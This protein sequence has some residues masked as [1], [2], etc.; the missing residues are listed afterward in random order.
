MSIYTCFRVQNVQSDPVLQFASCSIYVFCYDF[1]GPVSIALHAGFDST[2]STSSVAASGHLSAWS[3]EKKGL[4]QGW[5]GLVGCIC[6]V[7]VGWFPSAPLHWVNQ[8]RRAISKRFRNVDIWLTFGL[9]FCPVTYCNIMKAIWKI[10]GFYDKVHS[11]LVLLKLRASASERSWHGQVH[12]GI[13][14]GH[15][16]I[17]R[18]KHTR[19]TTMSGAVNNFKA[20]VLDRRH[21]FNQ[22]HSNFR[23]DLLVLIQHCSS[24]SR[25]GAPSPSR[26]GRNLELV[27]VRRNVTVSLTAAAF[28]YPS[29]QSLLR[30]YEFYVFQVFSGF[31]ISSPRTPSTSTRVP[32]D[33]NW[34]QF[35]IVCRLL[36]GLHARN[37]HCEEIPAENGGWSRMRRSGRATF[38][39]SETRLWNW[40]RNR[41][42]K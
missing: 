16:S 1:E 11:A 28:F 19:P 33:D 37:L 35:A 40:C 12:L 15:R 13:Q 6:I 8:R 31:R 2:W 4:W 7:L 3:E 20:K 38:E 23:S 22:L 21:S 26:A 18:V 9:V 29:Y 42:G 10:L 27:S 25:P 24:D 17:Q 32:D 14:L 39:N 5:I 36:K 34:K 41:A 30:C